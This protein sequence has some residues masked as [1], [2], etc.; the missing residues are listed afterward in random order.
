[1]QE[2]YNGSLWDGGRKEKREMDAPKKYFG[3][4]WWVLCEGKDERCLGFSCGQVD[5]RDIGRWVGVG[6]DYE[7][8]F[9]HVLFE[10]PLRYLS[11]EG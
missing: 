4:F 3:G 5:K 6:R 7:F 1:M 2:R 11:I 9:R 10:V 8:V